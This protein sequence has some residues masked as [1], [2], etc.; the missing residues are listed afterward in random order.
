M[1]S[2]PGPRSNS[3]AAISSAAV[4]EGTSRTLPIPKRSSSSR[5]HLCV[6]QPSPPRLP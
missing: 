4:Q 6:K 3:I 1:T 2:S 5:L